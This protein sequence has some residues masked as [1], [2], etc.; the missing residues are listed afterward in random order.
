M[1]RS[2]PQRLSV[3]STSSST[4]IIIRNRSDAVA[5]AAKVAVEQKEK[6]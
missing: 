4:T 1:S 3:T 5:H 6:S 2:D